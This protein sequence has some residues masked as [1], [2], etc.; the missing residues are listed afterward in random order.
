MGE[1]ACGRCD[2]RNAICKLS[3][4]EKQACDSVMLASQHT[5]LQLLPNHHINEHLELAGF[6]FSCSAADSAAILPIP[7]K[8]FACTCMYEVHTE[9]TSL[10]NPH[11]LRLLCD[12]PRYQAAMR[13]LA[14]ELGAMDS[15]NAPGLDCIPEQGESA[16]A[17]GVLYFHSQE[18]C[19]QRAWNDQLPAKVGLYHAFVRPHTKDSIEHKLFIV[20]SGS[21]AFA[22][23][24]LFRLW[25][26]ASATTTCMQFATA[27]ETSWLREATLRNHNRVAA[28]VAE[29]FELPVTCIIDTEDPTNAKRSA[30]PSTVT[31]QHDV[32]VDF[33]T[34][35]VH[36]VNSG[37]F[38]DTAGNGVLFEMHGSEGFWLFQGPTD[39]ASGNAYGAV[40]NCKASGQS[41]PTRT[42][43]FHDKFPARGS[44]VTATS[45]EGAHGTDVR[46]VIFEEPGERAVTSLFP[47]EVFIRECEALG[48][49]R[50]SAIISLM[51]ILA[52]IR[53]DAF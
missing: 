30:H 45:T 4:L 37:C 28:R 5:H 31:M 42:V 46:N 29:A 47:E 50:N 18:R 26:D 36:L 34:N 33:R 48:F 44:A 49:N 52:H 23:D 2:T 20:V 14:G 7:N 8:L 22:D 24:E 41:F 53:K 19:D 11:V 35:T 39:H 43:W 9:S 13:A 10:F 17:E 21:L 32:H 38:T 1:P 12:E 25:Q 15:S 27:E 6:H 3:E 40:F 16:P 51:P